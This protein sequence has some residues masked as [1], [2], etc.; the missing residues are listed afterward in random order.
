VK[1]Y[2]SFSGKKVHS[3]KC[4]AAADCVLAM[5]SR[6]EW[7]VVPEAAPKADAKKPD[8]KPDVKKPAAK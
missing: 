7:D 3:T 8:A 1:R 2:F 4:D 6:D 5:D